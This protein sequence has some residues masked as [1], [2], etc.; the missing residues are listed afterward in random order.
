LRTAPFLF[1]L[2]TKAANWI[3]TAVLLWAIVLHY[4]E[5]IFAILALQ[6]NA[7]V[8]SYQFDQ[9]YN[10]LGLSVNY[11]KD[12]IG[13]KADFV[14]IEF[15]SILMQARLPPD[16]LHR[17]RNTAQGLLKKPTIPHSE[18][19]SAVGV[20]SFAAKI[21]V[22]GRAFLRRL[23][24]ASRRPVAILHITAAMRADLLWWHTFLKD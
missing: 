12:A 7:I 24:N 11:S 20:L 15:D 14:G 6:A 13:T 4:L 10:E 17:A 9:V 23:F 8:Y 18:L 19:E 3:I 1:D 2:S 21:V 22:P 16:K 5:D